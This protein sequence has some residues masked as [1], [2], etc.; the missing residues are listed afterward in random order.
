M[1]SYLAILKREEVV[2]GRVEVG[3][4]HLA[5]RVRPR[6]AL[7][8]LL[9]HREEPNLGAAVVLVAVAVRVALVGPPGEWLRDITQNPRILTSLQ[10]FLL[11]KS[12]VWWWQVLCW[13]CH[14]LI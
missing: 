13:R 6:V 8:A 3:D 4:T 1:K 14:I 11:S 2:V 5:R 10:F 12:F 9:D 7:E